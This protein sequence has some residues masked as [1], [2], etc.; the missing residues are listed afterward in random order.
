MMLML[1]NKRCLIVP[2]LLQCRLIPESSNY[3]AGVCLILQHALKV[4]LTTPFWQLAIKTTILLL[5]THGALIGDL[6]ETFILNLINKTY[7]GS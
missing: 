7:A 3:I 4:I 2:F 5:G 1:L 6:M